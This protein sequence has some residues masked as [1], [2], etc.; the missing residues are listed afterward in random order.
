MTAPRATSIATGRSTWTASRTCSSCAPSSRAARRRHRRNIST[1]PITRR[2]WPGSEAL[3]ELDGA[4]D[5]VTE[6]DLADGEHHLGFDARRAFQPAVR[7][8]RA[9]GF[10]DLL[11]RGHADDLEEFAQR[12]V[13]GFFVHSAAP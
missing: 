12:H 7:H 13:E 4:V 1:C 5:L 6:A 9:N 11:L 2:R 8:G 10:F 3:F